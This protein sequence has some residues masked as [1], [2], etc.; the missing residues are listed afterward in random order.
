MST[1]G[2]IMGDVAERLAQFDK[3]FQKLKANREKVPLEE[4]QGPKFRGPY[5]RLVREVT[6]G[7][8][9]YAD[10]YLK[11]LEFPRHPRD[12]AGN[13]WLDKR[14][15]AILEDEKKPGGLVERYRAALIE[16]LDKA[17]YEDLVWRRYDRLLREAFDPYWQRHCI[18]LESGWVY[19][20]IFKKFWYDPGDGTA[21]GWINSDYSG[22]DGRYPPKIQQEEKKNEENK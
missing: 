18:R 13:E 16:R 22:W 10:A 6:D 20:D 2:G 11:C 5:N 3:A 19:N 21:P 4:L 12:T 9:W 8:D 7:A 17:E 15:A 14:I 1:G